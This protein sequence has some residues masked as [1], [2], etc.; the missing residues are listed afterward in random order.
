M[1]LCTAGSNPQTLVWKRCRSV[2]HLDSAGFCSLPL[3]WGWTGSPGSI[4]APPAPITP[5]LLW[6]LTSDPRADACGCSHWIPHSQ[7]RGTSWC[8]LVSFGPRAVVRTLGEVHAAPL[9]FRAQYKYVW[10]AQ[11]QIPPLNAMFFLQSSTSI[12]A[13]LTHGQLPPPLPPEELRQAQ[14]NA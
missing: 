13:G 3:L 8:H 10:L 1:Q 7:V 9:H 6:E 11:L 12:L 4:P 14:H 2:S 5:G